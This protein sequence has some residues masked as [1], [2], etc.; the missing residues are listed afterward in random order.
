MTD[1]RTVEE[2][3][4]VAIP[5]IKGWKWDVKWLGNIVDFDPSGIK[6]SRDDVY[7]SP[8]VGEG[9]RKNV[10]VLTKATVEEG[11]DDPRDVFEV[12]KEKVHLVCVLDDGRVK[13]RVYRDMI[14]YYS[15]NEKLL[16]PEDTF[17]SELLA[18]ARH[19]SLAGNI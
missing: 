2:V 15:E 8:R 12:E 3:V 5:F 6:N 11:D 17:T 19:F 18:A 7:V 10:Y 4:S 1:V 13:W 16:A 9:K 14:T